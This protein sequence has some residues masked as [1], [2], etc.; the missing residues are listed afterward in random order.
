MTEKDKDQHCTAG[1]KKIVIMFIYI[2]SIFVVCK[3]TEVISLCT[4]VR[5]L[6][7]QSNLKETKVWPN[8]SAKTSVR[9]LHCIIDM[10]CGQGFILW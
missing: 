8:F 3:F 1:N 10:E 5:Q 6:N 2:V 9:F 4:V 7:L